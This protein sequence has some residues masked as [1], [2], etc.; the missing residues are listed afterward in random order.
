MSLDRIF[1][2]LITEELCEHPLLIWD[3]A[4]EEHDCCDLEQYNTDGV[5]ENKLSANS[6][7]HPSEVT[8]MSNDT[9]DAMGDQRVSFG[10]LILHNMMEWL[11]SCEH[12]RDSEVVPNADHR[13][14][15]E[16]WYRRQD[17]LHFVHAQEIELDEELSD[18]EGLSTNI[19]R[20]LVDQKTV[21]V[22]FIRVIHRDELEFTEMVEATRASINLETERNAS[23]NFHKTLFSK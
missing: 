7:Y 22:K 8:G 3:P 4:S 18:R 23:D 19:S 13:D 20:A 10:L 16:K 6:P 14:A 5:V 12:G 15:Y 1:N 17:R 11:S 21:P 2:V 9:I